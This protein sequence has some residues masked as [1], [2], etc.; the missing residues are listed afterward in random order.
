LRGALKQ[1]AVKHMPVIF[2]PA[3]VG[4]LLRAIWGYTG[5]S[6]TKAALQLS[7]MLFQTSGQWNGH[8]LT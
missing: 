6:A 5:Q 7:A 3:K 4:E 2:E 1:V 8:G